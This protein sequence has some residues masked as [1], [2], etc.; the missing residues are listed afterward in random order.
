M[1]AATT[2]DA[3]A[4]RLSIMLT[5]LRLPTVKRLWE[6]IGAQSDREG[7]PAARLLSA[8]FEHEIAERESRRLARHRFESNLAAD[9][10]LANFDFEQVPTVSW[11]RT[12]GRQGRSTGRAPVGIGRTPAAWRSKGARRYKLSSLR[13]IWPRAAGAPAG[14]ERGHGAPASDGDG[15]SGGAKPPG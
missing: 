5:E 7:W 4:A 12:P 6:A 15:G 9:K 2:F 10:T 3:D 13:T 11:T 8:L 1:N 14:A